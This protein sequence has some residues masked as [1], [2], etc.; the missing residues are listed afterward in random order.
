[1]DYR[2]FF[3]S[4][5]AAGYMATPAGKIEACNRAFLRLF[6]FASFEEA[7]TNG[8]TSLYPDKHTFADFLKELGKAPVYADH[9]LRRV[10]GTP[11]YALA[12]AAGIFEQREL[13]RIAGIFLEDSRLLAAK[14]G[15]Y[16]ARRTESLVRFAG[17]IAPEFDNL[18]WIAGDRLPVSDSELPL[19]RMREAFRVSSHVRRQLLAFSRIHTLRPVPLNLNVLL[20]RLG[21]MIARNLRAETKIIYDLAPSLGAAM[22]DQSQLEHVILDLVTNANDA[23][24]TSGRIV[25]QT[26]NVT[27]A[28]DTVS[29]AFSDAVPPGDY[30]LLSVSDN[31]IGMDEPV[32]ERA[33]DPF[34]TTKWAGRGLGLSAVHGIVKQSRGFISMDSSPDRGTKFSIFL[35]RTDQEACWRDTVLIV[36][37]DEFLRLQ[38]RDYFEGCGYTTLAVSDEL[39]ACKVASR[40]EGRID[41]LVAELMMR[42]MSGLELAER[43]LMIRPSLQIV[44]LCETVELNVLSHFADLRANLVCKPFLLTTLVGTIRALL[45]LPPAITGSDLGDA[46]NL[47]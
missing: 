32:R 17:S 25:F 11:I 18:L 35:P 23:M 33:F 6:G 13:V 41:V 26:Q 27:V 47:H 46:S 29:S 45:G 31:G 2:Q 24:P 15:L 12:G 44:L 4:I 10:D 5:P 1:M 7:Q 36:E 38:M 42:E 39:E 37:D 3:N 9:Q 30:I 20:T 40:H 14:R 21:A 28:G 43:L 19:A 34:F 22:V 16:E 8:M